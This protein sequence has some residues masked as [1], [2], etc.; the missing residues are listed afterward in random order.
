MLDDAAVRGTRAEIDAIRVDSEREWRE[1]LF[2]AS[3]Q[4]RLPE[5]GIVTAADGERLGVVGPARRAAGV[6]E[7]VRATSSRLDRK[8]VV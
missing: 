2:N 4:D 7:D 6:E 3:F 1:L 8:S 5:I